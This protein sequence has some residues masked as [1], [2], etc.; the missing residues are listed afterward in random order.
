MGKL[1]EGLEHGGESSA[2]QPLA[3]GAGMEST[4]AAGGVM[5]GEAG[6]VGAGAGGV[7]GIGAEGAE[8]AGVALGPQAATIS[9]ASR[10]APNIRF[11]PLPFP[12][13]LVVGMA[14]FCVAP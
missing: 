5:V 14:G 6:P 10:L 9:A 13:V 4:G 2:H 7:A 1:S 12:F 8:G 11:I 3:F